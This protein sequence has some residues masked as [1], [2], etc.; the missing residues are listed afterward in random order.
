LR[1]TRS[2]RIYA[3]DATGNK[4]ADAV[5]N[6]GLST[7]ERVEA[8]FAHIKVDQLEFSLS[9][10]DRLFAQSPQMRPL[11]EGVDRTKQG[12]NLVGAILPDGTTAG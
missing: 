4:A 2:K 10:Y 11:F 6:P 9:F 12:A 1:D 8:S 7:G 5:K 3:C